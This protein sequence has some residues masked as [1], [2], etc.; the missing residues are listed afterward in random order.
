MRDMA[1]QGRQVLCVRGKGTTQDCVR[2]PQSLRTYGSSKEMESEKYIQYFIFS[3]ASTS[4]TKR[5]G[6]NKSFL[7]MAVCFSHVFNENPEELNYK[8]RAPPSKVF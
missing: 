6:A 2:K 5:V 7:S 3:H 8:T 4:R 1:T